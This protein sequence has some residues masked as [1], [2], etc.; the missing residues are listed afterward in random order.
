MNIDKNYIDT[1][2][3]L[4]RMYGVAETL[5]PLPCKPMG[6]FPT[7]IRAWTSEYMESPDTDLVKFFE[8]K[9]K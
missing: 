7:L 5:H 3:K 8:R 4:S 2:I 1:A 6:D 9:I